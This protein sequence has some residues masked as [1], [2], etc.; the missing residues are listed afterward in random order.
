MTPIVVSASARKVALSRSEVVGLAG[1][2]GS[3]KTG[4]GCRALRRAGGEECGPFGK[5]GRDLRQQ[6]PG[7]AG[8]TD[9]PNPG[10]LRPGTCGEHGGR[11]AKR[12]KVRAC[13]ALR[14]S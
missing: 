12:G 14:G 6:D 13:V 9:P 8:A 2:H 1:T 5:L 7:V 4:F 11:A 10:N 3:V